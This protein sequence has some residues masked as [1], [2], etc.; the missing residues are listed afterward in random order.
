MLTL[1]VLMDRGCIVKR[2]CKAC[3][4]G[5]RWLTINWLMNSRSGPCNPE[6][7]GLSAP[8]GSGDTAPI[9]R[10]GKRLYESTS[11]ISTPFWKSMPRTNNKNALVFQ[12]WYSFSK[13][14]CSGI[15]QLN[16][17]TLY[18]IRERA[19]SQPCEVCD[20][21]WV[22]AI[23]F[24]EA[25]FLKFKKTSKTNEPEHAR[26]LHSQHTKTT[27]QTNTLRLI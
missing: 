27:N 3:M 7:M 9:E 19:K 6:A 16:T 20:C 25:F 5:Q 17:W 23:A 15:G 21:R 13:V 1:E 26:D 18:N 11:V 22:S 8:S 10:Q 14:L 12:M 4:V 24:P 2:I